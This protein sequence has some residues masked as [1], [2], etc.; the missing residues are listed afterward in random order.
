M[1]ED[2]DLRK[3]PKGSGMEHE[4]RLYNTAEPG[5][6]PFRVVQFHSREAA[7]GSGD[8]LFAV[9]VDADVMKAEIVN[10]MN[11]RVYVRYDALTVIEGPG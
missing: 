5:E 8:W 2:F 7:L 6:K 11:N 3:L 4:L 9:C 10:L 1:T